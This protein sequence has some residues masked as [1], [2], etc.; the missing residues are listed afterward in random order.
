MLKTTRV[1]E[2]VVFSGFQDYVLYAAI[3]NQSI[4]MPAQLWE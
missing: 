3:Q 2:K 1:V 4:P